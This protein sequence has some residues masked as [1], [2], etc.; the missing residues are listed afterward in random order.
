M[1][2]ATMWSS[3]VGAGPVGWSMDPGLTAS[4]EGSPRPA[5]GVRSGHEGWEAYQHRVVCAHVLESP[6][7]EIRARGEDPSREEKFFTEAQLTECSESEEKIRTQRFARKG[8]HEVWKDCRRK[9]VSVKERFLGGYGSW[10]AED[11]YKG[12]ALACVSSLFSTLSDGLR[13]SC[14]SVTKLIFVSRLFS[15]VSF[16]ALVHALSLALVRNGESS[17]DT[18][19]Q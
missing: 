15:L 13:E 5:D 17:I 9:E 16:L 11:W 12:L 2:P 18:Y 3:W 10:R 6:R 14:V 8:L 19:L 7:P 1:V 4:A